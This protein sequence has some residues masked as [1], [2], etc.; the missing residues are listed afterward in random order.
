MAERILAENNHVQTVSYSLPNKHY[1]PVDMRYAGIDNLTPYV[2][3]LFFE[4]C[5]LVR[6]AAI[7]GLFDSCTAEFQPR[8]MAGPYLPSSYKASGD[9]LPRRTTPEVMYRVRLYWLSHLFLSLTECLRR[10]SCRAYLLPWSFVCLHRCMLCMQLIRC[11]GLVCGFVT[12]CMSNIRI[13][14]M[15]TF[16]FQ[17]SVI[18]STCL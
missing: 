17:L 12:L 11:P 10:Y 5:C 4:S 18:S 15:T 2:P 13:C 7:T 1:I 9:A 8:L 3:S 14:H 6:F 16:V